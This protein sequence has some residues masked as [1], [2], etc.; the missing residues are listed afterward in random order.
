[1]LENRDS[2]V[3]NRTYL[4]GVTEHKSIEPGEILKVIALDDFDMSLDQTSHLFQQEKQL[5]NMPRDVYR[6]GKQGKE[7][8]GRVRKRRNCLGVS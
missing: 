8:R 6:M 1:M 5:C 3:V 2:S 7:G 4:N